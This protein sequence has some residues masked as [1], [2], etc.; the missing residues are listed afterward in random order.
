MNRRQ[1]KPLVEPLDV[2]GLYATTGGAVTWAYHSWTAAHVVRTWDADMREVNV[3]YF[4]F[5]ARDLA[6]SLYHRIATRLAEGGVIED[7][8]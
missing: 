3:T 6:G 8:T 1:R 2:F 5:G 4:G 7:E